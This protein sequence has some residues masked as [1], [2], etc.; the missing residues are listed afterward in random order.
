MRGV[1]RNRQSSPGARDAARGAVPDEGPEGPIERLPLPRALSPTRVLDFQQC[2][3]VFYYRAIER[4]RDPATVHTAK[5][6]LVHDAAEKVFDH[7]RDERNPEM[8]FSLAEERWKVMREEDE[9]RHLFVGGGVGEPAGVSEEEFMADVE[10]LCANW[11]ELERVWNFE[12]DE[13]EQMLRATLGDVPVVGILD[14]A[15]KWGEGRLQIADYKTGKTPRPQYQ[16]KAFFGL[17]VYAALYRELYGQTPT[18]L[19]L[20]YLAEPRILEIPCDDAVC[21]AVIGELGAVWEAIVA[22]WTKNEWPTKTGPLCNWCSFQDICPAWNVTPV[23]VEAA[24]REGE[25]AGEE[26]GAGGDEAARR[27]AASAGSEL[28]AALEA[29]A[30]SVKPG[31]RSEGAPGEGRTA[32]GDEYEIVD[33]QKSGEPDGSY[34]P[35]GDRGE[36]GPVDAEGEESPA[37]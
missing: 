35:E 8:M 21:D 31:D 4:R 30:A 11:F 13:R 3:Q 7:P 34:L 6:T 37:A 1:S 27:P 16:R 23:P 19:R 10:R 5:G 20:I 29:W 12:P 28:L 24:S 22:A 25:A 33:R 9:Y 32:G 2:P 36:S 17:R 15:T 18:E 26:S 14:R